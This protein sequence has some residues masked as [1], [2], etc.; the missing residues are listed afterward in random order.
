MATIR[1]QGAW[2]KVS[3][4]KTSRL[5]S[6]CKFTQ[7]GYEHNRAY[8]SGRWDGKVQ[9]N[10]GKHIPAGLCEYVQR[11]LEKKNYDVRIISDGLDEDI[12][13]DC[14]TR[15]ILPGIKLWDNQYEAIYEAI[16]HR[17]GVIQSPQATGKLEISVALAKL[18]LEQK[19]WS[20]IIVEPKVTLV[21]DAVNRLK[22]YMPDATIGQLGGGKRSFGEV[23]VVSPATAI[24]FK[25]K[26]KE[27]KGR[28]FPR[29]VA[30]DQEIY[31]LLRNTDV[32]ILDEVHHY[33]STSWNEVA[34]N[35][36]A[37]RRYGLSA[38]PLKS[39][40]LED[41][42]MMGTTGPIIY[43]TQY[44]Q[45]QEQNLVNRVKIAAVHSENA[46]H[47]D[48][49]RKRRKIKDRRGKVTWKVTYPEYHDA[50]RDAVRQS[51][52]FNTS[53]LR[54]VEWL[55]E[56]NRRVLITVN[57][58]DHL[59]LLSEY[60]DYRGFNFD[61]VSGQTPSED[62][63]RIMNSIEK[64]ELDI[65]L[66]MTGVMGEGANL[67]GINAIVTLAGGKAEVQTVQI[68]GRGMRTTGNEYGDL[69]MVDFIPTCHPKLEDHG[70]SRV[71]TYEKYGYETY[72]VES[73]P[74]NAEDETPDD[75]LPFESWD[76]ID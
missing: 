11:K 19:G 13:P 48:F 35:C 37:H 57:Y 47:P 7:Q 45:L 66:A 74:E 70:F 27:Q 42:K 55:I 65:L 41:M 10:K 54:A 30:G 44:E 15:D 49:Y 29:E 63:G 69:W 36:E 73:W 52:D 1:L 51:E 3:D 46:S 2:A 62:R 16:Q 67:K 18:F 38:T 72:P 64:G 75:L 71:K 59:R 76:D 20:T 60:L 32:M 43:Q 56:K 6:I 4:V 24:K 12:D 9:L 26:V 23:T 53:V 33:S 31:D 34:M 28:S 14:V 21:N 61:V 22:H 68:V 58:L 8:Q 25:T 5:T 50:F 39:K 40:Q 17:R